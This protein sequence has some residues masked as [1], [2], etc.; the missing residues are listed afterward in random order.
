[1]L[2][3][4]E[5]DFLEF[6]LRKTAKRAGQALRVVGN[7]PYYITSPIL[8]KAIAQR[9]AIQDLIILVQLEV[10]KRIVAEPNTKDYGILSVFCQFYGTPKLL[11]KVPASAFFPRPKVV[12]ALLRLDFPR[13]PVCD[14]LDENLFVEVV[15]TA[16][17]KRRKTLRNSL[18]Y[19]GLEGLDL[20]SLHFNLQLRPEQLTLDDF[21]RLSNLIAKQVHASHNPKD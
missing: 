16:F 1:L 15:R 8:L 11:F 5:E 17:G 4:K 21:V 13:R 19:L 18:R 6:D 3:I 10:G 7:I 9:E 14:V 12:S 20:S 2:E